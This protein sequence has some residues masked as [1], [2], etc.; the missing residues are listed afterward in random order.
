MDRG[1]V[2][3]RRQHLEEERLRIPDSGTIAIVTMAIAAA[4]TIAQPS[5]RHVRR[6]Q[7]A[8]AASTIGYIFNHIP[9]ASSTRGL[10][11]RVGA[12]QTNATAVASTNAL[13]CRRS[14]SC[15]SARRAKA[16][17]MIAIVVLRSTRIRCRLR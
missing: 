9:S 4:A 1:L 11:T 16:M 14:R 17:S 15:R 7:S 8:I 12:R 13:T 3:A 6:S 10:E 5:A 2:D